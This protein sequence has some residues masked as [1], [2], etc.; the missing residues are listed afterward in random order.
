MLLILW[1]QNKNIHTAKQLS[2]I[3]TL[4]FCSSSPGNT[5]RIKQLLQSKWPWCCI[6]S[7]SHNCSFAAG[8]LGSFFARKHLVICAADFMWKLAVGWSGMHCTDTQTEHLFR[9]KY[10]YVIMVL[11][12]FC[13]VSEK[14]RNQFLSRWEQEPLLRASFQGY[15]QLRHISLSKFLFCSVHKIQLAHCPM[16]VP[17]IGY[18]ESLLSFLC[19][20]DWSTISTDHLQVPYL[21]TFC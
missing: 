15:L 19:V 17:A 1:K 7:A 2:A 20:K 5:C 21:Y 4:V 8:K 18:T 6:E 14:Q 13:T 12:N 11:D 9:K 3:N 10:F 16:S